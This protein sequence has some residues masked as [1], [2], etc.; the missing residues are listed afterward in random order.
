MRVLYKYVTPER[1]DVLRDRRIRF[2]HP[3]SF[4]DPFEAKPFFRSLL[5]REI[6][7]EVLQLEETE[8][9]L[10]FGNQITTLLE[11]AELR[12]WAWQ[13]KTR[14]VVLL[15]LSEQRDNLLMWAHYANDH[16]GFVLG[17]DI[18][19]PSFATRKDGIARHA[20]KVEYARTRPARP[21]LAELSVGQFFA[22]KSDDWSYEKEWR[23]FDGAVHADHVLADE[24]ILLF[25]F[26]PEAI[27]EVIVGCRATDDFKKTIREYLEHPAYRHVQMKAAVLDE[28]EYRLNT[29]DV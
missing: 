17:L 28:H 12:N 21:S 7:Q 11:S 26:S 9:I 4:N 19:H 27:R 6:V 5:E 16:Q 20:A 1:V 22:T 18:E 15:S 23:L 14:G 29:V 25:D 3:A 2:A 8:T 10:N 24:N 13:A